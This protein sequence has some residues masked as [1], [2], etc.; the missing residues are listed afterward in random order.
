MVKR[1]FN[2]DKFFSASEK[3]FDTLFQYKRNYVE[4]YNARK[5][6]V[7]NPKLYFS[8]LAGLPTNEKAV[9]FTLLNKAGMNTSL[10]NIPTNK[11]QLALKAIKK[12][13]QGI[14]VAI[15]SSSIG[16]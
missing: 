16:I 4:T 15:K 6:F 13:K 14:D 2:R 1:G 8:V 5:A 11:V 10:M 12:L 9:A 7:K 3:T